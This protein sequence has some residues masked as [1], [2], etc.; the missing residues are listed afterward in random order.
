LGSGLTAPDLG[1]GRFTVSTVTLASV[2][3]DK[4]SLHPDLP[5]KRLAM[6]PNDPVHPVITATLSFTLNR[7]NGLFGNSVVGVADMVSM[8]FPIN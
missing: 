8:G 7:S 1:G 6:P 3:S 4:I 5:N 2:R